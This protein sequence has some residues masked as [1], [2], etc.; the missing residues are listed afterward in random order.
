MIVLRF[1][2]TDAT[3][4]RNKKEGNMYVTTRKLFILHFKTSLKSC[5]FFLKNK[6]ILFKIKF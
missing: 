2:C 4:P 5:Y 3:V 1:E 6:F